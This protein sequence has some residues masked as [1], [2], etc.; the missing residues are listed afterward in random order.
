MTIL[1]H[2]S[3]YSNL[4]L[5]D[6]FFGKRAHASKVSVSWRLRNLE[7]N[8]ITDQHIHPSFKMEYLMKTFKNLKAGMETFVLHS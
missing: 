5:G 4:F 1:V 7:V 6:P 2:H 8:D 3:R